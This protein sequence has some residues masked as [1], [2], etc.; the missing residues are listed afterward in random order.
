MCVCVC[1]GTKGKEK[2]PNVSMAGTSTW[3]KVKLNYE[4]KRQ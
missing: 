1:F 3:H 2:I 4:T